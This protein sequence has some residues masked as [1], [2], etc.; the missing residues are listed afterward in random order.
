MLKVIF[1][2]SVSFLIRSVGGQYASSENSNTAALWSEDD[3]TELRRLLDEA[4]VHTNFGEDV[5]KHI[6]AQIRAEFMA[7]KPEA[8]LLPIEGEKK[9]ADECPCKTCVM[10]GARFIVGMAKKKI[11]AFCDEKDADNMDKCEGKDCKKKMWCKFWHDKPE[12]ALG[13]VIEKMRPASD[14]W[15]WC[16]GHGECKKGQQSAVEAFKPND[17][18]EGDAIEIDMAI[19]SAV[20][21]EFKDFEVEDMLYDIPE[22]RGRGDDNDDYGPPHPH[23][24]R[25]PWYARAGHWIAS[26]FHRGPPPPRPED[27]F[28]SSEES[29][30]PAM[31]VGM[32]APDRKFEV[33]V[34]NVKGVC[35]KC[36]V[37]TFRFVMMAAFK[38]TKKMCA[39]TK[40]PFLKGWCK[41]A[42]EHK[43][44]A[45]GMILGKVEPWKYAIGRCWHPDHRRGPHH[46]P[47]HHGGP[48]GPPPHGPPHGHHRGHHRGHG[49]GHHG[50]HDGPGPHHHHDKPDDDK[51][52]HEVPE[53]FIKQWEAKVTTEDNPV[54][55]GSFKTGGNK[56]DIV[57]TFRFLEHQ[58]EHKKK[59]KYPTFWTIG[60]KSGKNGYKVCGKTGNLVHLKWNKIMAELDSNGCFKWTHGYTSC[61][62]K[63][64]S[65]EPEAHPE[66][67]I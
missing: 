59:H 5:G 9:T 48:P 61:P 41:W 22:H 44:M 53:K 38:G 65:E 29:F 17:Y 43:E 28:S 46:G 56:D 67:F 14:A 27:D 47:P 52:D 60:D 25:P 23:H 58:S 50:H 49:R 1:I 45:A 13:L 24:E 10:K 62:V 39:H 37:K 11:D 8:V 33:A 2:T 21:E 31:A 51:P 18:K 55:Y 7:H 30:S 57:D 20:F 54:G 63:K 35:K 42:G 26:W 6:P 19:E 32:D 36:Y 64:E 15:F 3:H 4:T 12:V 40:C 66:V 16:M 34:P